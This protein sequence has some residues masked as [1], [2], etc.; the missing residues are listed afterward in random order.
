MNM[1]VAIAVMAMSREIKV[2]VIF[3]YGDKDTIF[4]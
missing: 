3:I 2:V 4:S 1:P